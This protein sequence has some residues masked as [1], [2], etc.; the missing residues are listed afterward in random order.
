MQ[1]DVKIE[2]LVDLVAEVGI[3]AAKRQHD[4]YF[5]RLRLGGSAHCQGQ[6]NASQPSYKF[7]EV[8]P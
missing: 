8:L 5:N 6:G 7:H 1:L 3:G 4:A 2:G